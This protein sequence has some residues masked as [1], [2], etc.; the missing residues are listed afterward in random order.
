MT[1]AQRYFVVEADALPE[2]FRLVMQAKELLACGAAKSAAQA[3]R[4]AGISRSAFYKYKDAVFPYNEREGNRI[5]T[6]HLIL[7]DRPGVL[8][9]VIAAFYQAGANILTLNQ[10][11]PVSGAA[12]VSISA[13]TDGMKG[14]LEELLGSIQALDGVQSI[15]NISGNVS[16]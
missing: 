10:N 16:Q 6:L 2:V 12:P 7:Q 15:E 3:A 9:P 11:I 8:A 4:M 14:S 1:D 5:I 13:S